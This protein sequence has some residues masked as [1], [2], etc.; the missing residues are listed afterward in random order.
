MPDGAALDLAEVAM[1]KLPY[2]NH[3]V[4]VAAD[5]G[6]FGVTH[7]Q[8]PGDWQ[9]P[10]DRPLPT[11]SRKKVAPA[12]V[13][14]WLRVLDDAGFFQHPGY[15]ANP[16]AQGGTFLIVRA[17]RRG[18]VHAIV[19]QNVRPAPID[20]LVRAVERELAR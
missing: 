12:A 13:E 10:F 18:A 7:S 14:G 16:R 2:S 3:R 5:G 9:V 4:R 8:R 17:R 20:D 6:L 15:E 19:Y 11:I 1:G